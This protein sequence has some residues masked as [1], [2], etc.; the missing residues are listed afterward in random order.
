MTA[1]ATGIVILNY[2]NYGETLACIAS[3][4]RVAAPPWRAAVVDND[5]QNGSLEAIAAALRAQGEPYARMT[6][7]ESA[8]GPLPEA[9]F[10]LIQCAANRG[11]AAGNNVGLRWAM[12]QGCFYAL[13]LNNDTEVEAGFLSELT[14][15]LE[16]HADAGA[17]GPLI[18]DRT[19]AVDRQCARR[20]PT[21]ADYFWRLGFG[22]NLWPGNP[23]RRRH[24]YEGEYDFRAPREVDVLGGSCLL[25][26]MEALRRI[27]LLD[28][29]TFLF[30]EE[31]ILHERLRALGLRSYIVPSAVVRHKGGQSIGAQPSLAMCRHGLDSLRYYLRHYRGYAPWFCRLLMSKELLRY[32]ALRMFSG[33]GARRWRRGR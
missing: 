17:V 11:Y 13:I 2:R 31:F 3:L 12:R 8:S 26:R 16:A 23:W 1:A 25:L 27:G 32:A 28:E 19:G 24:F 29:R 5:S 6:E 22:A 14:G 4:R 30:L 18:L 33:L 20:R 21:P 15:F 9:R 10:A 7:A